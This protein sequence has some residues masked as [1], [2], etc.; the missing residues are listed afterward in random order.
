[1]AYF[2]KRGC[3]CKDK[4]KCNCGATW[5]FTVDVGRDETGKRLQRGDSGF[6][7]KAEAVAAAAEMVSAYNNGMLSIISKKETVESY[8]E[9]YLDEVLI[10]EVEPQTLENKKRILVNHVSPLIGKLIMT[11]TTHK[12]IQKFANRLTSEKNLAPGTVRGIM[13]LVNQAFNYAT[14]TGDIGKNVVSHVKK[15]KNV[16]KPHTVWSKAQMDLFLES[17]EDSWYYP[18]YLIGLY[19]GLRPGETRALKWDKV[20]FEK[21][22]IT[23]S[24]TTVR[25]KDKKLHIKEAPKTDPSRRTI[26]MPKIVS[27]FL[28]AHKL[29]QPPFELNLVA[30]SKKFNILEESTF[31][32]N[33]KAEAKK[34]GLPPLTPHELRHTNATYLLTPEKFGGLGIGFKAV[35]E[36]LGH[37]NSTTTINT[38]AHVFEGMEAEIAEAM[39]KANRKEVNL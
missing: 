39:N 35:S 5:S 16:K 27:S 22:T 1:M 4:K 3:K 17:T 19:M 28:K 18:L 21:G 13:K 37:A 30:P 10:N 33:L 9:E 32:K 34:I 7:T 2:R 38:Y 25:T 29:R 8:M 14:M 11:K 26:S 6:K 31:S 24:R 15:P 23:I 20:D 12:D 36:R